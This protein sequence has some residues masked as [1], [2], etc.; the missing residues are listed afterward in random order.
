MVRTI[1]VVASVI[2][3]LLAGCGVKELG[4]VSEDKLKP[5][6]PEVVKKGVEESAKYLPPG[7]KMPA[8]VIPGSQPPS[9]QK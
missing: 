1:C 8:G 4:P 3:L 5:A 2:V 7:V 9:G 6:D